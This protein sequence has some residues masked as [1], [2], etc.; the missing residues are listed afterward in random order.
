MY[1]CHQDPSMN[2]FFPQDYNSYDHHNLYTY[3]K[4]INI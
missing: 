3:C 4:K 1:I 2:G